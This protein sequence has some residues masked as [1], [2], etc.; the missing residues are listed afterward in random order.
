MRSTT[1]T[2]QNYFASNILLVLSIASAK[3]AVTLLVIAIKPLKGVM[4]ACYGVLAFSGIWGVASAIAL[5]LQCS[6]N[7]WAL[8][9]SDT[10]TC[11]DQYTMQIAI[12]ICDI[13]SDIA[14]IVLP[15]V[16]MQ[17][18]QTTP[19]KR[20]MVIMLFSLRIV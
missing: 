7:R 18:V 1:H 19:G 9:P 8:G 17:S 2:E 16:M 12:R 6:P 5:S 11:V 13:I 14:I 20:W 4:Y 3:A 10:D 15:I